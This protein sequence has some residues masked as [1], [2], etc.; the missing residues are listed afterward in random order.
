MSV[1]D[2]A[3]A[4]RVS[5]QAI[6]KQVAR[7]GNRVPTRK[8]GTRLLVDVEAFD[9]VTGSET[10]PAQ[11]LRN[12]DVNPNAASAQPTFLPP[13][14]AAKQIRDTS[15]GHDFS[16]NRAKREGYDAELS[17]IALEREM[18]KLVP[19]AAVEDAMVH[20]AQNLVRIIDTLPS[21]SDD[22]QTRMLL[23]KI[24]GDLRAALYENMKLTAELADDHEI[25][26][27][28]A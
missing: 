21:A 23:K 3:E 12:R 1:S 19:V 25:E 8:E 4:R 27:T 14:G 18:G 15:A 20:C 10:D 6:S 24:S 28:A 5:K 11:A 26:G 17:R 13:E 22:P 2:I 7:L 16:I 9:R